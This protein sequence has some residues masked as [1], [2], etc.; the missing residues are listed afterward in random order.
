M[1]NA[2]PYFSPKNVGKKV[3]IIH[4]KIGYDAEQLE[5][6]CIADGTANWYGYFAKHYGNI[7]K[8]YILTICPS[9]SMY[10]KCMSLYTKSHFHSP[11]LEGTKCPSAGEQIN[12]LWHILTMEY[13]ST[14]ERNK[15]LTHTTMW[16]IKKVRLHER[17]Q[18]QKTMYCLI[19]K[20]QQR[21]YDSDGSCTWGGE[22]VKC[23]EAWGNIWGSRDCS[24]S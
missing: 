17:H 19:S 11:K 6:L 22:T 2:H 5:V 21:Q 9:I 3:H 14:I 10:T 8:N 20:L 15:I 16:I 13:Y 18:T 23:E 12:K 24:L 7:F 1:Y 4:G